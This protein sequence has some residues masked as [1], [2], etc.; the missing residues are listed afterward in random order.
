MLPP[1][2][3]W[4]TALI[5]TLPCINTWERVLATAERVESVSEATPRYTWLSTVALR[6][7][8]AFGLSWLIA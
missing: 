8:S 7:N 5:G 1:L 3:L 4:N 2:L 6:S